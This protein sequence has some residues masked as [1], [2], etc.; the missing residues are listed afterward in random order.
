MKFF[1]RLNLL[2]LYY[3]SPRI[4]LFH[5]SV[6]PFGKW[7]RRTDMK[8]LSECSKMPFPVK[9][10]LDVGCGPGN[11]SSKI[12]KVFPKSTLLGI[13]TSPEMIEFAK[14]NYTDPGMEFKEGEL[15]DISG[16][17]DLIIS[18]GTWN[19]LDFEDSI[20]KAKSML[21]TPGMLLISTYAPA[22]FSK[23]HWTVINLF[24]AMKLSPLKTIAEYQTCMENHG[25]TVKY[26]VTNSWEKGFFIIGLQT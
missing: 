18:S 6:P 16:S 8:V 26:F 17:F 13:D 22:F 21:N 4:Y 7:K 12:H 14:K 5:L 11:F 23:I 9:T 3:N 1:Q 2:N 20:K 15:Y 10:I 19:Y 24:S 25:M